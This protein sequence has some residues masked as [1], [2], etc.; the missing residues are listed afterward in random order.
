MRPISQMKRA[1]RSEKVVREKHPERQTETGT[2]TP[3]VGDRLKRRSQ[4]EGGDESQKSKRGHRGGDNLK[5]KENRRRTARE[6]GPRGA[7][8]L[9][10]RRPTLGVPAP[11][12][13]PEPGARLA[14]R[15]LGFHCAGPCLSPRQH[16]P[17]SSLSSRPRRPAT[18]SWSWPTSWVRNQRPHWAA[19]P[20]PTPRPGGPSALL[21]F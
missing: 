19:W 17:S 21:I 3:A 1:D 14:A 18:P 2:D 8:G 15:R 20:L 5:E 10:A 11:R 13:P 16:S 9:Q 6:S 12:E 4:R 7:A